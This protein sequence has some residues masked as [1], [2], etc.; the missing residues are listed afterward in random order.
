MSVHSIEYTG[1]PVPTSAPVETPLQAAHAIANGYVPD[2][3]LRFS[4]LS[5][6]FRDAT[7]SELLVLSAQDGKFDAVLET[8]AKAVQAMPEGSVSLRIYSEYLAAVAFAWDNQSLASKAVMRNRPQD[9]SPF[10]WTI[11][12]AIK[13]GIPSTMFASLLMSQGKA[14]EE[15]WAVEAV[16]MFGLSTNSQLGAVGVTG[17]ITTNGVIGTNGPM[18]A[19][20]VS[21]TI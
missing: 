17:P 13:K 8:L 15:K 16:T 11:V 5:D 9:A 10:L 12:S 3:L 1:N 7:I 21:P 18:G 19:V 14:A 4:S 6:S 20:G 2:N